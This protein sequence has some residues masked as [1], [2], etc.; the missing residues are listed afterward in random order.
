MIPFS[1][2]GLMIVHDQQIEEALERYRPAEAQRTQ[3]RDWRQS[4][5]TFLAR[6]TSFS[7]RKAKTTIPGCEG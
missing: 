2:T 5:S 1:H 7:A 3:K 6:F 4:V